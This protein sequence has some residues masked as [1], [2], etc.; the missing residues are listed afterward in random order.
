MSVRKR[1]WVSPK[2]ERKAA[3]LVD[4][5]DQSGKRHVKT[6]ARKKEADAFSARSTVEVADGVHVADRASVTVSEAARMWLEKSE[7]N[8]LERATCRQYAQHVELHIKPTIGALR[9]SELTT[10]AVRDFEDKLRRGTAD[11]SG[12]R[13]SALTAKIL[14]SLGSILAEAQERGFCIRNAVKEMRGRRTMGKERRA[15]RRQKG[16]LKAG[17]DVPTREEIRAVVEALGGRWRPLILTAVFSGLRASELR[18]LRWVDVDLKRRELHVRQRADRF[19]AIGAPKSE[20]GERTVPLPPAVVAALREWRLACPRVM[21]D[22][23]FPA[24]HGGPV[25]H[26]SVS[27]GFEAVQI[28]AGVV[29]PALDVDGRQKFDREGVPAVEAK[30][31][32]HSLRHFYASWCINRRTDGGLELPA[33][34][35]QARLGHSSITMTFDVYGHLFPRGDD[36]A[37]LEAAERALLG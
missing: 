21:G 17:V 14:T 34:A 8:G 22:L 23:V 35:V 30:Y 28:A 7:R 16:R 4:Y 37:E 33:K 6:F 29:T 24:G 31:G 13:S 2:G 1:E 20:A 27:R 10:P 15:D 18:G 32:L 36:G 9:L 26:K 5:C 3:W 19:G 11:G 25:D 12:Q